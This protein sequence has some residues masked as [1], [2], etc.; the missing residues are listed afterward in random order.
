MARILIA[1]DEARF[2]AW[3]VARSHRAAM[4]CC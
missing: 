2:A 3:L 1:E 4:R